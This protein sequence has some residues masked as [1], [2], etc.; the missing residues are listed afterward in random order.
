MSDE[1]DA[2]VEELEI[3]LREQWD[4]ALGPYVSYLPTSFGLVVLHRDRIAIEEEDEDDEGDTL[5]ER[6]LT[7]AE[8]EQFKAEFPKLSAIV[9]NSLQK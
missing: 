1:F 6:P 7:P 5:S 8:V 9:F 3:S 4:D 2:R